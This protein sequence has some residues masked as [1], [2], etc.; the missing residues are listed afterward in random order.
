[1]DGLKVTVKADLQQLPELIRKLY[2]KSQETTYKKSFPWVD[3]LA[4]VKQKSV[5][6]SLD[7]QLVDLI[8]KQQY[9]RCWLAAPDIIDWDLVAGF[10]YGA[11]KKGELFAD[12]DLRD[13][14]AQLAE[15]TVVDR[16]TL[17][18]RVYCFDGDGTPIHEWSTYQC[19]NCELDDEK[20]NAYL[21]SGGKWYRIAKKFV[22]EVNSF[23]HALERYD[24]AFPDYC[25]KSETE[26][27]AQLAKT[28]K[29]RFILQDRLNVAHGGG[30][31]Q[32]EFCDIY[33][34]SGGIIHIK[35]YGGS[36]VLSH[37]FAQGLISGEL[38]KS[39]QSFQK[40]VFDKLALPTSTR[41]E[42]HTIVFGIVSKSRGEALELPFFSRLNLK[43]AVRRLT[44]FGYKVRI[45]KIKVRSANAPA[46]SADVKILETV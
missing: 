46:E 17:D 27:N 29:D 1:M 18:R 5:K 40:K 22:E 37:L 35:R 4:E 43:H 41:P 25:H 31:S 44:N 34:R 26:Y 23:V 39:D 38:F 12:L 9:E 7:I 33:D 16:L 32:I 19:I 10:R 6:A 45:A 8:A 36:S 20:G 30:K 28:Y 21:L 14:R 3:Q 13:F 24:F 42:D 15:G 11:P 2:A